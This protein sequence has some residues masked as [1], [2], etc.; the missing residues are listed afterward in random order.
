[1]A[2]H[3]G[4]GRA[5]SYN[6]HVCYVA[7]Y[8]PGNAAYAG[9]MNCL[10]TREE[11][12]EMCRGSPDPSEELLGD[13]IEIATGLLVVALRFPGMFPKWGGKHVI[14][15][16]L[17]IDTRRPADITPEEQQGIE[18]ITPLISFNF[19]A[20]PADRADEDG[21]AVQTQ[22]P[23]PVEEPEYHAA[24][25]EDPAV[26]IATGE[27]PE[28]EEVEQADPLGGLD[29]L[30]YLT[31]VVQFRR[32]QPVKQ[33]RTM[34]PSLVID[35]LL[36]LVSVQPLPLLKGKEP[37]STSRWNRAATTIH[38]VE[39]IYDQ[40]CMATESVR[41][42]E[43]Q[44]TVR[45]VELRDVGLAS[46][47]EVGHY[48]RRTIGETV[49]IHPRRGDP[50]PQE[51]ENVS[52]YFHAAKGVFGGDLRVMPRRGG[53]F[54]SRCWE[55]FE[56]F[57]DLPSRHQRTQRFRLQFLGIKVCPLAAHLVSGE[58]GSSQP[59]SME[60]QIAELQS[61]RD[62]SYEDSN[63]YV[64]EDVWV[65]PW[66]VRGT[67]GHSVDR[68]SAIRLDPTKIAYHPTLQVYRIPGDPRMPLLVL[69]V[70]SYV[71]LSYGATL[72]DNG[73]YLVSRPI[74]FEQVRDAWIAVPQPNHAWRFREVRKI[75]SDSLDNEIVENVNGTY[76][77]NGA[78]LD[79]TPAKVKE[80]LLSLNPGPHA[81]ERDQLVA[82]LDAGDT[83]FNLKRRCAAMCS[84]HYSNTYNSASQR[85]PLKLR[86]C[87]QC[88]HETPTKLAICHHCLAIF[89]CIG[90]KEYIT[91]TA[92]VV[93]HM[94]EVNVD[95]LQ[96]AQAEADA[97]VEAA[98]D[99][100]PTPEPGSAD[101]SDRETSPE[102]DPEALEHDEEMMGEG[103]R[104]MAA[105]TVRLY[106]EDQGPYFVANYDSS[107]VAAQFMD[108]IFCGLIYDF[109]P[110]FARFYRLPY[111]DML[112]RFKDGSRH[113]AMGNWPIVELD[114]NT[115][116]PRELTDAEIIE[117][118][119]QPEMKEWRHRR[120]KMHKMLSVAVR[121]CIALDYRREHFNI[122]E[123]PRRTVRADMHVTFN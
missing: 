9:F 4:W 28:E 16:C 29:D 122:K 55:G 88:M 62:T 110:S 69:Y 19:F 85:E 47:E 99:A 107:H 102:P 108:V 3:L 22:I 30:I 76:D 86:V 50:L 8:D 31:M 90:R 37:P 25:E 15:A 17:F 41:A 71:L 65:R 73:V 58:P 11:I 117:H 91:P 27:E 26:S 105:L 106:P 18:E 104:A 43:G 112:M 63:I 13:I 103:D 72:S 98:M 97:E 56:C 5:L 2:R 115:G 60:T 23:Q 48:V 70:P 79:A 57:E 35:D 6:G 120:Y 89:D 12:T 14:E 109:W 52:E 114:T 95:T 7:Y 116:L 101:G 1:R 38:V 32:V 34:R 45:G 77:P 82:E 96:Q 80:I 40:P 46:N 119:R 92:T 121:G 67:S 68:Y 49:A 53:T 64:G 39:L 44:D 87:P 100:E 113:D 118:T 111:P 33:W 10:F 59:V 24:P 51:Y 94:P 42:R 36:Y 123:H 93:I 78:Y 61:S 54:L 83:S 84:R 75:L 20:D 74:P 81:S 66:A 21:E